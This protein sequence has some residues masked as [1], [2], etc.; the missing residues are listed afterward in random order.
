[1]PRLKL[2]TCGGVID[3]SKSKACG[4]CGRGKRKNAK[5]TTENG[6]GWD[7]QQLS[8]RYRKDYPL[9]AECAK[10]GIAT[11]SEEVHHIVPIAEAPWLRLSVDNLTALCVACHR[12]IEGEG[13]S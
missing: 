2:C 6:Y 9:C 3:E 1:M 5:T 7:W 12:R 10:R 13:K 4:R 8:S 11:P